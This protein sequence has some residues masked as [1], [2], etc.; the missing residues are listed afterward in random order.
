[1]Y[2]L[3]LP[4]FGIISHHPL[5]LHSLRLSPTLVVRGRSPHPQA[6]IR[7]VY[8]HG[9]FKAAEKHVGLDSGWALAPH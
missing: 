9:V 1:M 5:D 3:I 6:S 4:G 2:V 7:C 8:P